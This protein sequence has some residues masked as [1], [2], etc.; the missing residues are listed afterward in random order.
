MM[1]VAGG[2]GHRVLLDRGHRLAPARR[3]RTSVVN[4]TLTK[5][6]T[7]SETA[8]ACGAAV[9][10]WTTVG[11]V[12]ATAQA[13]ATAQEF[14]TTIHQTI[15]RETDVASAML[16]RPTTTFVTATGCVSPRRVTPGKQQ[17]HH[18]L[19][20]MPAVRAM[21][22]TVQA[23]Q[24]VQGSRATQ[25]YPLYQQMVGGCTTLQDHQVSTLWMGSR[26]P[27]LMPTQM[28]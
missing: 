6:T 20:W 26:H 27:Q 21:L 25:I 7:V 15:A 8:A 19:R 14:A 23:M 24:G 22:C 18:W 10:C 13:A 1:P 5:K 2:T 17:A 12:E 4:V 9:L 3:Q 28:W 16:I 11:F